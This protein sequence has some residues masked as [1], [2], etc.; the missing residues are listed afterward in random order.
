MI[1]YA[2]DLIKMPADPSFLDRLW[3]GL[4]VMIVGMA[5]V[6]AVLILLWAILELF[7]FVSKKIGK[8]AGAPAQIPQNETKAEDPVSENTEEESEEE[9]VAAITAAI[10][11]VL[12]K[13]LS[14]FRVVSFKKR[15]NWNN[16]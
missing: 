10:S 15:N 6:F 4:S 11:A 7:G 1:D 9:M 5:I 3:F 16:L 14:G 2:K 12:E 13:P 8:K